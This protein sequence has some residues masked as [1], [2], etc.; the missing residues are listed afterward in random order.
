MNTDR[1]SS[2]F[3][4]GCIFVDL[5]QTKL[6]CQFAK[7]FW[8]SNTNWSSFVQMLGNQS[9]QEFETSDEHKWTRMSV[10]HLCASVFICGS[11]L[12]RF[13][14]CA[15]GSQFGQICVRPVARASRPRLKF[16]HLR[17]EGTTSVVPYECN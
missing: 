10:D 1:C 16:G 7:D 4:G 5:V 15:Q 12:S 3:I 11:L 17:R 9:K 2:V 6:L 13:S 8:R 14:C